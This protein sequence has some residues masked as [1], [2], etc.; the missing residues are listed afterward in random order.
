MQPAGPIRTVFLLRTQ[1]MRPW[2][3]FIAS[4]NGL[5]EEFRTAR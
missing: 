5:V 2:L 1:R 3:T 4:F